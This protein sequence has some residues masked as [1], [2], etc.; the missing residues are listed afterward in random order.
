MDVAV[1]REQASVTGPLGH[2]YRG[3]RAQLPE[4]LRHAECLAYGPP[5]GLGVLAICQ[6]LVDGPAT[7]PG[8]YVILGNALGVAVAELLPHSVPELR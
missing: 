5:D 8:Q 1:C 2:S 3:A 4:P 6:R 7:E